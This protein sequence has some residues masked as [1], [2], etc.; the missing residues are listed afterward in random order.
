MGPLGGFLGASRGGL[1]LILVPLEWSLAGFG[2]VLEPLGW[3]SG[4]GSS[5]SHIFWVLMNPRDRLAQLRAT[6]LQGAAVPKLL[7]KAE[8]VNNDELQSELYSVLGY[9]YS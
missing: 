7:A 5:R 6:T 8:S 9:Q 2:V 3:K 1:W 4:P